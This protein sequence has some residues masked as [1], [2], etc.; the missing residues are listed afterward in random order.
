[1]GL[2]SG[3]HHLALNTANMKE[4]IDF[5]TDVLGAEL[6]A[7]Y[8]MHG[9]NGFRHCFLKLNDE[10][11]MSFVQGPPME[12]AAKDGNAKRLP[13]AP[14]ALGH[15]AFSVSSMDEMYAMRD[16]IREHGH[17]VLGPIDHGFCHSMYFGGPEGLSLEIACNTEV[18]IDE[19]AWIDPEVVELYG[20]TDDELTK[21]KA[22]ASYAAKGGKVAQPP[23]E[24]QIY[25]TMF[26]G[27]RLGEI[28]KLSEAELTK[29]MGGPDSPVKVEPREGKRLRSA[30]AAE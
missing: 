28:L 12:E 6:K 1:M 11:Y 24:S 17:I 5:F 15:V 8:W 7:L 16:R 29:L 27:P 14:G 22:P 25:P 20:I 3:V 30:Q 26:D 21:Y 13:P 19:R 9:T 2:P 4:Q 23:A 10:S 18:D